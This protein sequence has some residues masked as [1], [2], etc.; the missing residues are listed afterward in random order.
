MV[1]EGEVEI[2][3]HGHLVQ[4][5]GPGGIFGEMGFIEKRPRSAKVVA[6]TDCEVV[7]IDERR[8]AFLV[9]NTSFFAP[10]I[11]KIMADRLRR[12]DDISE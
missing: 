2:Y 10:S 11:M 1:S 3:V 12:T 9:Q 4:S 8:F 7:P 6:K 5:L